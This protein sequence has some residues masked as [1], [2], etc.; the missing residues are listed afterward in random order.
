MPKPP[1]PFSLSDEAKRSLNRMLKKGIHP[2]Q[3][4]TRARILLRLDQGLRPLHIARELGLAENTVYNVR[5][6]A[7]ARGWQD[8]VAHHAGGGRPRKITAEARAQI[9]ALACSDPPTG[10]S[11]WSLRLLADKAVEFGFVEEIS[12]QAVREILKKTRSSRT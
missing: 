10:R 7:E 4:L 2:A 5:N 6:K 11:Q 1:K 8:A 3:N 12:H 9:T